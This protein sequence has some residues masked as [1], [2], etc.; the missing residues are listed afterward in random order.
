V[1]IRGVGAVNHNTVFRYGDD[2]GFMWSDGS[3]RSLR[4]TAAFGDFNE[5]ALTLPINSFLL[6]RAN[7]DLLRF[8]WATT[9]V[10]QG[11]TIFTLPVDTSTDNNLMLCMDFR[12]V[13][14]EGQPRWSQW[15]HVEAACI[16]NVIDPTNNDKPTLFS[17][18]NDGFVRRMNR[19][20]RSV[21]GSTAY[22]AKASTPFMSYGLPMQMKTLE[23][24]AVG[25]SARGAHDITLGFTL[26]DSARK[27]AV[28][29]QGTGDVLASGGST[30]AIT[31]FETGAGVVTV[32]SA[33]HGL[34]D[35]EEIAIHSTTSYNGRFETSNTTASTFDIVATFV[36]DDATG[37]WQ[38]A[39]EANFF[40]LGISTLGGARYSDR[41]FNLESAGEFRSIQYD[42]T[43]G[44]N[45]E[46]MEVHTIS[47]QITEGALSLEN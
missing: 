16:A 26:D 21:D 13:P 8:A 43:Q 14:V 24:A 23:N 35:G 32:T 36:A 2:I 25:V 4:A 6:E 31:K 19:A 11:C 40:I 37:T 46:D 28:V 44:G 9:M 33:A 12:F 30:G 20:N 15:N 10:S 18:G 7:L 41:F 17:G 45:N 47:A 22:E 42:V 29:S 27:T 3:V 38:T 34:S 5:A 39:N 1:F